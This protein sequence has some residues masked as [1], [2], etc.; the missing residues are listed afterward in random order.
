M[1]EVKNTAKPAEKSGRYL[2]EGQDNAT[3]TRA[4]AKVNAATR[5]LVVQLSGCLAAGAC[6]V[7]AHAT[8]DMSTRLA[9]ILAGVDLAVG[10]FNTGAWS[11]RVKVKGGAQHG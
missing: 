11:Q 3:Q 8:G 5:H 1:S 10:A 2:T 7:L 9:L 6:I 4:A